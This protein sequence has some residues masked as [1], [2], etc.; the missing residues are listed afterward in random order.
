MYTYAVVGYFD[1]EIEA[2]FK[3]VWSVLNE[4]NISNYGV[5]S[6]SKR[7]HI[8]I[9]DYDNVEKEKF[10]GMLYNFC[11]GKSK[12]SISF[13]VLG[14][15]LNSGTLFLAPSLSKELTDLH[16]SYHTHFD[17]F[18]QNHSSLYLPGKWIPHCTIA[19]RLSDENMLQAF[20]YCK[21]HLKGIYGFLSQIA[22]IEITVNNGIA[23]EDAVVFSQNLE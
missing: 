20:Q 23:I 10:I 17:S 16:S 18:N 15:F 19:S 22:L 4:S 6:N 5:V 9:A 2:Q 1:F 3:K 12:I 13:N 7:P 8:T 21:N 11:S 14:T